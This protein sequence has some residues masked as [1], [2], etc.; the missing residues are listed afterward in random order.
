MRMSCL[1][2]A[3]SPVSQR[4]Q[5][6][7]ARTT[8]ASGE[9]S[10]PCLSSSRSHEQPQATTVSAPW[11]SP[12][13]SGDEN[14]PAT[15]RFHGSPANRPAGRGRRG[16]QRTTVVGEIG[17]GRTGTRIRH[18]GR[19]P[20][21]NEDQPLRPAQGIDQTG[22]FVLVRIG[23]HRHLDRLDGW[24][25]VATAACTS[26]GNARTTVPPRPNVAIR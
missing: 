12:A 17:Q 14:A 6:V 7:V 23:G 19:T 1:A 15:S 13:V 10:S 20:T 18:L 26:S 21:G 2:G 22:Q 3:S 16:Q 25:V 5:I 8:V 24:R 11:I 9:I 4:G